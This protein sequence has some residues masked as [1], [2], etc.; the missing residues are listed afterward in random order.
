M[1]ERVDV[2]GL[3]DRVRQFARERTERMAKRFV[4][5]AQGYAPRASGTGADS[6]EVES[7]DESSF[8]V[9]ARIVV[10]EQYMAYQNFG[11]GVY[12]PRGVPITPQN[13]TFL[14]FPAKIGGGLVFARSVRGTE[15]THFWERAVDQ[16][17]R[18]VAESA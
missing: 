2:S 7:V 8:G 15:P 11:T 9:T 6:I 3:Q 10:G 16:W 14:V 18:I 12:G 5:V 4:E 1:A 17:G 13:G